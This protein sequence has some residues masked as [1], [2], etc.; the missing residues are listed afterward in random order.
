[1]NSWDE[2][3]ASC[4]SPQEQLFDC[5]WNLGGGGGLL[6]HGRNGDADHTGNSSQSNSVAAASPR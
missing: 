2:T 3:Q 4:A 5:R 1:M 6:A